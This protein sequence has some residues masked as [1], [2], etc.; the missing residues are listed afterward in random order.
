M[1]EKKSR[2]IIRDLPEGEKIGQEQMKRII[3]GAK[4]LGFKQPEPGEP[5]Y[6][7]W[8]GPGLP[9]WIYW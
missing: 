9:P 7:R 8:P 3:G 2:I 4:N 5:G 1:E 6:P